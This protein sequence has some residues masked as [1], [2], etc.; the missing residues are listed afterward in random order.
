M[1][2]IIHVDYMCNE[3]GN[4]ETFCPYN[5]APYKEKFTLFH[6]AEEMEDSTNDGFAFVDNDGNA[7]VRVGGEKMNYKVGDKN[8]KLFYRLAELVDTVYNDYSY[9][10]I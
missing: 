4:C 5:S 8:T 2:Q 10:L 9:L 3:C 1:H 7:I 6:R